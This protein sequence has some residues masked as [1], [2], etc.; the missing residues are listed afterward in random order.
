[1]YVIR[2]ACQNAGTLVTI[3]AVVGLIGCLPALQSNQLIQIFAT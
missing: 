1:M 3:F 2:E